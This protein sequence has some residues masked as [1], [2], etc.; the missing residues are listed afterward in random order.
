[1][2]ISKSK[3]RLNI[4][5]RRGTKRAL[6]E[7]RQFHQEDM[8]L[9]EIIDNAIVCYCAVIIEKYTQEVETSEAVLDETKK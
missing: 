7:V 2:G 1:M 3:C 9:S 5:I 8:S 6:E 4:T